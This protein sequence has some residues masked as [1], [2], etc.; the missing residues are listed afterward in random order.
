[1]S[2]D[3]DVPGLLA[4]LGLKSTRK[5]K[6]LWAPC[7]FHSEEDASFHVRDQEGHLKHGFWRCFGCKEGGTAVSLVRRLQNLE[8]GEEAYRWL[9]EHGL[10]GEALLPPAVTVTV[11]DH[12]VS[13]R[14]L[15]RLPG[16][17]V[18]DELAHWPSTAR[19]YAE[20]RGITPD[21]VERWGLGWA[22]EGRLTGR[23]VFPVFDRNGKLASYA[24]RSFVGSPVRYLTPDRRENPDMASLFGEHLWSRG[25]G[26]VVV[27]E[28][29]INALSI[30]RV[31]PAA[32][33][34]ETAVVALL[35]SEPHPSQVAR[36]AQSPRVL[37]ASDPD[38]AGNDLW[39]K[40]RGSLARWTKVARVE[41]PEGTDAA[42]L[43]PTDLSA[44]LVQA[45][46]RLP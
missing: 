42:E 25:N 45:H 13:R 23:L 10:V 17:V 43:S 15:F 37:V 6:E 1:V 28:G 8:T 2:L 32:L 20:S 4:A 27:A 30:E 5:G 36:L 29:A 18:V 3:V 34:P 11:V 35:G 39:R 9:R 21:Q 7:P 41:F 26:L 40:L 16:G 38:R 44:L 24:A 31:A 33:H 14:S 22:I 12:R 19:R 46:D